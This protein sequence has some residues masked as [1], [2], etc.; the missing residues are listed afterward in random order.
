MLKLTKELLTSIPEGIA[1]DVMEHPKNKK[2][3]STQIRK[4]YDDLLLLHSKAHVEGCTKENFHDS[5]LPLVAF[6]KAK[7]AYGVGRKVVTDEFRD[8][9]V[10]YIDQ[11]ESRDDFDHFI[12]FY[13]ALIGYTKYYENM[14][15]GNRNGRR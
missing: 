13:Q 7:L 12:L 14:A 2:A 10:S 5:I 9:L 4:Y 6:S 11:I 1:R 8:K 3:S 15:N